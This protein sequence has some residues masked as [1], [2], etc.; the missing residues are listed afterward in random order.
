MTGSL[1]MAVM[2]DEVISV[3]KRLLRGIE[4]NPETLSSKVIHEVGAGGHFLGTGRTLNCFKREFWFP[5]L[6]D[7]SRC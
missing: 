6:L 5:R 7:S 1:Q 2:S 3:V 4:L